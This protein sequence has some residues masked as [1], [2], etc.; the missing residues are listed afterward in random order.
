MARKP[1]YRPPCIQGCSVASIDDDKNLQENPCRIDASMNALSLST[2]NNEEPPFRFLDLP[3]ELRNMIY[4]QALTFKVE[5][6][7]ISGWQKPYA[8]YYLKA[9]W[10]FVAGWEDQWFIVA[11]AR[12][13]GSSLYATLRPPFTSG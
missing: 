7:H 11:C 6:V 13:A 12:T 9:P 3:P 10:C 1:K 4:K 8:W 5:D 2:S